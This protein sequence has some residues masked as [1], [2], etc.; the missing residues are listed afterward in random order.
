MNA[1]NQT[2]NNQTEFREETTKVTYASGDIVVVAER[3]EDICSETVAQRI[4]NAAISNH[5]IL[6]NFKENTFNG[7]FNSNDL[8]LLTNIT[9]G[10][11]MYHVSNTENEFDHQDPT[12]RKH[13]N[14]L[15]RKETLRD[16]TEELI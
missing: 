15:E 6:T 1:G 5:K 16:S 10:L 2:T 13:L 14:S 11:T 12:V 3:I 7:S 9:K 8:I 4:R